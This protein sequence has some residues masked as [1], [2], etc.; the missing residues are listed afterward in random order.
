MSGFT[1]PLPPIPGTPA[2]EMSLSRSPSPQRGGGW[3][4]PGLTTPY[5]SMSGRSTPRRM[6]GEY[7]FNANGGPINRD[8]SWASAKAKSE[9]INGGYP[10]F[11]TRN[12]GFFSRNAQKL[13]R[14][15][16]SFSRGGKHYAEKEKVQRGRSYGGRPG[17]YCA[18]VGR[19]L[20]RLRLRLLFLIAFV[21]AI[22]TFYVTRKCAYQQQ[23]TAY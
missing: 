3:S 6:Y 16:P 21:F 8:V 12:T 20:W 22:I 5:D 9:E 2:A 15:L 23:M 1:Q 18:H 10:K 11:S 7:P 17:R 4:S 14:S 13:Q 19:L